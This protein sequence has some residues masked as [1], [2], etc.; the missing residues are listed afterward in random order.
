M[1]RSSRGYKV[2]DEGVTLNPIVS[3]VSS[4]GN[5]RVESRG[6]QEEVGV[7]L[8][9]MRQTRGGRHVF[10]FYVE[11]TPA[12]TTM[13][14]SLCLFLAGLTSLPELLLWAPGLQLRNLGAHNHVTI[15]SLC[16]YKE[17]MLFSSIC[18]LTLFKIPSL[19]F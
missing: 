16:I 19:L 10:Y 6:G 18:L 12:V 17:H 5:R 11:P 14:Q 3:C 15:L 8:E 9:K 13:A 1:V 2:N 7:S 4:E